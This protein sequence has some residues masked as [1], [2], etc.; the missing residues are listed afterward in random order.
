MPG[1]SR[2]LEAGQ[3]DELVGT[4]A[5]RVAGGVSAVWRHRGESASQFDQLWEMLHLLWC[6][7]L[8]IKAKP[9]ATREFK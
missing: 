2:R 1:P 7:I 9:E 3:Q 8:N 6:T 4:A 5:A